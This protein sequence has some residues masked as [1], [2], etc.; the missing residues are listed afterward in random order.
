MDATGL[1]HPSESVHT[2]TPWSWVG[3]GA[4]LVLILTVLTIG[5]A[6][7]AEE[8]VGPASKGPVAEVQVEGPT[9]DLVLHGRGLMDMSARVAPPAGTATTPTDET[10]RG[11]VPI[12]PSQARCP[13]KPG[14]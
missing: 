9:K 7:D 11:D 5:L 8:T 14:C 6:R 13:A 12:L 1:Q 4:V 2:A 10:S 3:V